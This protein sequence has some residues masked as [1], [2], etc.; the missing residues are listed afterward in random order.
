M[1]GEAPN[2]DRH[3][4]WDQA[5]HG[6]SQHSQ[7]ANVP[8]GTEHPAKSTHPDNSQDW[9]ARKHA[10]SGMN[11][12][13]A[14]PRQGAAQPCTRSHRTEPLPSRPRTPPGPEPQVD[15][16][17]VQYPPQPLPTE[18]ALAPNIEPRPMRRGH[19]PPVS[20]PTC[21]TTDAKPLHE[22]VMAEIERRGL[23]VP[24]E[25]KA[26]RSTIEKGKGRAVAKREGK[27]LQG[28][29]HADKSSRRH[30]RTHRRA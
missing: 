18:T 6:D 20:V 7:Q 5:Y 10:G 11:D 16:S 25:D 27:D 28:K 14:R 4:T 15:H 9:T 8:H 1:G 26:S 3:Q 30:T 22:K 19:L 23:G 24:T 29:T 17:S 13:P 21:P 12:T 2:S